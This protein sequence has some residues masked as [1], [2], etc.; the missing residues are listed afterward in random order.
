[1]CLRLP[2]RG[3]WVLWQIFQGLTDLTTNHNPDNPLRVISY[4]WSNHH[5]NFDLEHCI[6]H[7]PNKTAG[8]KEK[9]LKMLKNVTDAIDQVQNWLLMGAYG[10]AR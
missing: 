5:E 4:H 9:T 7:Y 8:C 2:C 10:D 1:M 6:Q 3:E